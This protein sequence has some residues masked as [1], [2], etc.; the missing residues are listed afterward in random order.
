MLLYYAVS[1]IFKI[2]VALKHA[3]L[4][5]FNDVLQRFKVDFLPC[6]HLLVSTHFTKFDKKNC[7]HWSFIC[8]PHCHELKPAAA[9]R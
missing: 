6:R 8:K 3:E 5:L 7:V 9:W 4:T 2:L 1:Q